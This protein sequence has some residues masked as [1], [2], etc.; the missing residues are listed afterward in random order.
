[1]Q[2]AI[3]RMAAPNLAINRNGHENWVDDGQL[4]VILVGTG[5]PMFD[6]TRSG[7]CTAV[8]AGEHFFL[9]DAGPGT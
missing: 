7:P 9:V 6:T 1:M 5:C 2:A 3:G 8:L 4:H